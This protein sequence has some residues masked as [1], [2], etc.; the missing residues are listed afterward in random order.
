MASGVGLH[1][2]CLTVYQELK[3]GHKYKYILYA[4]NDAK[5][6]IVAESKREVKSKEIADLTSE[7]E[8]YKLFLQ[9]LTKGSTCRWGVFDF[10]YFVEGKRNKLTFISWAPASSKIKERMVFASS[11][12]ALRRSLV[13]IATEVQGSDEDDIAYETVLEKVKK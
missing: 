7:E 5:T 4:L 1:N 12:D 10:E 6:E 3:L 8:K 11:K 13:G 9:D 2:E